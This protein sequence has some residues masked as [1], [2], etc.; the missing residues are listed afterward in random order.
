M[1]LQKNLLCLCK[2]GDLLVSFSHF[3][4]PTTCINYSQKQNP[5]PFP[6]LAIART[7]CLTSAASLPFT[8]THLLSAGSA[9]CL[10]IIKLFLQE[11]CYARSSACQ[12]C[13]IVER[14]NKL[15]Q[16]IFNILKHFAPTNR[17]STTGSR[18]TAQFLS[19][20]PETSVLERDAI[21]KQKL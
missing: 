2:G 20:S 4:C 16:C 14:F 15:T 9:I 3:M 11:A 13:F 5:V 10:S 19:V 18:E 21:F 8:F 17:S 1:Q 7:S 12:T 6:G